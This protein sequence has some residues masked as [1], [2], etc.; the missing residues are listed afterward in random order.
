MDMRTGWK[1][2]GFYK[3]IGCRVGCAYFKNG[4]AQYGFRLTQQ[5]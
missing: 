2:N 3:C 4:I 5:K 1:M